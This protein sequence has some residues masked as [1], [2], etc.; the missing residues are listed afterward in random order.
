MWFKGVKMEEIGKGV[1]RLSE[2]LPSEFRKSVLNLLLEGYRDDKALAKE[3]D[4]SLSC[5]QNWKV[6]GTLLSNEHMPKILALALVHCPDTRNLLREVLDEVEGLCKELSVLENKKKGDLGRFME[7]LDK[8]SK[9]MVWYFTRNKHAGIRELAQLINASAD[10]DVLTR[11]KEVINPKAKEI[12]GKEVLKFEEA[13][14]DKATGRKIAFSWWLREDLLLEET[15][16]M[17]DIFDEKD[18][19]TVITEFPGVKEEDIEVKVESDILTISADSQD[20]EYQREV[21]LFYV[22][23]EDIKMKYNNGI[24]EVRLKKLFR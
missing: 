1:R 5:L 6:N 15:E 2:F 13:K 8:K 10:M 7:S 17:L 20:S 3:I 11:I 22:V 14:I 9:A 16:K 4:C 18:H 23:E 21:P 12:L 24:L 19:L